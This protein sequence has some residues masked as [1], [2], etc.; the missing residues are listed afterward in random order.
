LNDCWKCKTRSYL[1]SLVER[2]RRPVIKASSTKYNQLWQ[3][4]LSRSQLETILVSCLGAL[5]ITAINMADIALVLQLISSLS[6]LFYLW[7]RVFR[8][9]KLSH[10]EH[11]IE[12]NEWSCLYSASHVIH[13]KLIC[14]GYRSA[15]LVIIVLQSDDGVFHYCPV[16][17]DQ[18]D[19]SDFSYLHLQLQFNHVSV[20]RRS[21]HAVI[22]S[23]I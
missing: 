18:L 2:P 15:F 19:K 4:A 5:S 16:W 7:L 3:A 21:L 6:F 14:A 11:R 20:T 22:K 23:W 9:S 8:T 10:L 12:D 1:N 17:V 13:G